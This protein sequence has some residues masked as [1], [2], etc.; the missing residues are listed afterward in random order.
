MIA[1]APLTSP[2]TLSSLR[3]PWPW[4]A[5]VAAF[6]VGLQAGLLSE[7]GTASLVLGDLALAPSSAASASARSRIPRGAL[8]PGEELLLEAPL[9]HDASGSF[10]VSW[11]A[12]LI[13]ASG[14]PQPL[15]SGSGWRVSS[16][17]EQTLAAGV[18]L[19]DGL[20][21]GRY[22]LELN[23]MAGSRRLTASREVYLGQA[24]DLEVSE[25][26]LSAS[27]EGPRSALDNASQLKSSSATADSGLPLGP[28]STF[29]T[30]ATTRSRPTIPLAARSA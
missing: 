25:V 14:D 18:R 9:R 16:H 21:W 4:L 27:E 6:W 5:L 3:G 28:P 13:P 17:S 19:P 24:A 2:P 12:E 11:G 10:E 26:R 30:L 15:G 29:A 1:G 20:P 7:A 8:L 23:V 22:L